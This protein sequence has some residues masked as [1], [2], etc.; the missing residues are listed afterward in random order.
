MRFK[1][2]VDVEVEH[3]S[4]KFASREELADLIRETIEGAD[5]GE[6]EGEG[7][8]QYTTSDWSVSDDSEEER[9]RRRVK[10]VTDDLPKED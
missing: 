8:G 5:A 4:G 9:P 3:S 6:W 1:F 7:E 10:S 2:I